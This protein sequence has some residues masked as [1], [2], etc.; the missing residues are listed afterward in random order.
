MYIYITSIYLLYI[1]YAVDRYGNTAIIICTVIYITYY[2]L[3]VHNDDARGQVFSI[4][5]VTI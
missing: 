2:Y 5:Q 4:S 1:F 3:Q